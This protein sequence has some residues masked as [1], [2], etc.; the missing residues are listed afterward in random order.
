MP[1]TSY[2]SNGRAWVVEISRYKAVIDPLQCIAATQTFYTITFSQIIQEV[3]FK[4]PLKDTLQ[5]VDVIKLLFTDS[6]SSL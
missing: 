4:M 6:I 3:D 1:A 5:N 2:L